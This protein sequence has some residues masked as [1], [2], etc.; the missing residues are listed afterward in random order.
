MFILL[1]FSLLPYKYDSKLHLVKAEKKYVVMSIAITCLIQAIYV[2]VSLITMEG[3]SEFVQKNSAVSEMVTYLEVWSLEIG[4]IIMFCNG[5]IKKKEQVRFL[6]NISA[7]EVKINSLKFGFNQKEI[8]AKYWW[9]SIGTLIVT[10]GF[11][12][13][14]GWL[15]VYILHN[16]STINDLIYFYFK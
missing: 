11:F 5:M 14:I 12:S 1:I 15:V 2:T 16:T 8:Y 6:N 13:I 10:I 3:F 7:I 9:T 4:I